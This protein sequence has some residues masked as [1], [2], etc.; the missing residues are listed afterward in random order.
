MTARFATA[1]VTSGAVADLG[2]GEGHLGADDGIRADGRGP[3]ELG[4]GQ[5]RRVA[6]DGHVDVDP[7]R[8]RVDDRHAVAH[9]PLADPAVELAAER[10]EL[11]PVVDALGLPEVVEHVRPHGA[12]GLAGDRD[13]VGE[14]LLALGVVGAHPGQ[15]VA[16]DVDVEGVDA[17]VDLGDR[18]LAVG[19]VTV[20]DDALDASVGAAHDPAVARRVGEV[21]G[22]DRDDAARAVVRRGQLEERVTGEERDV[23]VRDDDSAGQVAGKGLEGALD[24]AAGALDV[25]LVGD[26]ERLVERRALGD[27]T[28]PLVAHDERRRAR[29]RWPGRRGWRGRRGGALRCGAGPWGWPTASGCPHPRRGR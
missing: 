28:V 3:E 24:R 8:R 12:S 16:Q 26:D 21:R 13:D 25:V 5:H 2:V 20:L 19:G 1:R 23:A 7:R 4:R 11:D 29:P 10:G 9:V 15:G 18:P 14:V 27:D 17:R 22:D 6:T